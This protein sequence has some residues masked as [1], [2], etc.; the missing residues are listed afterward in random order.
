MSLNI[1][2]RHYMNSGKY[3]H[4]YNL[5]QNGEI[6]SNTTYSTNNNFS[7]N[8]FN[9]DLVYSWQFAPGSFLNL[10]YKNSIET[11]KE[12]FNSNLKSNFKG[13]INSPQSNSFSIR[14]I[15]YLDYQN[16]KKA[17]KKREV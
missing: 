11:E 16:V 2:A 17:M 9:I 3:L 13:T 8:Y 1:S 4:Y 7:S 15:Y 10:N 6:T 12:I 14:L 5:E